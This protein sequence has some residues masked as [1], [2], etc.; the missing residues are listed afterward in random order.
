MRTQNAES[1]TPKIRLFTIA[2]A[3]VFNEITRSRIHSRRKNSL[4]R[5]GPSV[6]CCCLHIYIFV[7]KVCFHQT[8]YLDGQTGVFILLFLGHHNPVS[9][10][11]R[12]V[13]DR[14]SCG[15]LRLFHV[16]H[17]ASN[18][19]PTPGCPRFLCGVVASLLHV[20]VVGRLSAWTKI[21]RRGEVEKITKAPSTRQAD[22][23][24]TNAHIIIKPNITCMCE[25]RHTARRCFGTHHRRMR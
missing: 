9:T 6:W 8:G 10:S 4:S 12:V 16:N 21:V 14:S 22:A 11:V 19:S 7:C 18:R 13:L 2:A 15:C 23:H 1:Y 20:V 25:T 5:G 17:R 24:T 3:Q